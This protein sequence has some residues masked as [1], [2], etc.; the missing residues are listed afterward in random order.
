MLKCIYPKNI[1]DI[2]VWLSRIKSDT[3]EGSYRTFKKSIKTGSSNIYK[4]DGQTLLWNLNRRWDPV[5]W[6]KSE[7]W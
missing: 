7:V 1:D 6:V 5:T 4:D 3:R 2:S